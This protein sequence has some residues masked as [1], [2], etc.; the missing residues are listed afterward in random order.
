MWNAGFD[1]VEVHAAN[2]YLLEQFMR[3]TANK[4]DD[5]YGG[6]I[7]NRCRLCLEV[8]PCPYSSLPYAPCMPHVGPPRL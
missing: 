8:L 2:G 5:E 1:G 4:R 6:S 3:Q 7:P